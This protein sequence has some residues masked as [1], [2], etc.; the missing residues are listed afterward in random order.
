MIARLVGIQLEAVLQWAPTSSRSCLPEPS[1]ATAGLPMQA[2]AEQSHLDSQ[3]LTL[4]WRAG[5]TIIA[6]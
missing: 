2:S 1:A 6:F 5:L 3:R 4:R